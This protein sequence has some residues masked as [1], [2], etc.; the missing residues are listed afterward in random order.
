MA[1]NGKVVVVHCALS[2][3]TRGVAESIRERTGGDF[4]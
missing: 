1:Q 4:P 2:G 3:N